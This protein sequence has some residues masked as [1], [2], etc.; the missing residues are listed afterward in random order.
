MLPALADHAPY[1]RISDRDG[2]LLQVHISDDFAQEQRQDILEWIEAI[3]SSLAGVYG[4]WPRQQWQISVE[5]ASGASGDSIP[6]AQ[7]Q[8]GEV[9]EV[10]FFVLSSA[11]RESLI[12]NWTGYH[13]L[14]HLLIP[15]RGWGDAWFSEGLASY[16]QNLLQAR[17]GVITEAQMWQ[18]LLDGFERGRNDT[19]F[20]GRTLGTVSAEMRSKG[21][22]MR[23]YWS[24]A[25]YFLAADVHLRH[26]SGGERSLDSALLKLN[27]CCASASM[28]VPD[29]V[30]QLDQ[31]NDVTLFSDL[32]RQAVRSTTLPAYESL[33]E[34]LAISIDNGQ[35][36]LEQDTPRAILRS[37]MVLPSPL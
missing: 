34:Q 1:S 8:R 25:W 9:D 31:L 16:Y 15:Y 27:D 24:G 21:G 14:A 19:R 13:E 37:A 28:S 26:Q 20:D 22:F 10:E 7:V 11:S 29:M 36:T 30:A 35:L 3:A 5:S 18:K 4:H 12:R 23:V 32:Y 33:F 6:W 17:S 2:R